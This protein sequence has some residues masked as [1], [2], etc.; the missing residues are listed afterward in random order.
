MPTKVNLYADGACS[1]NPG[2]GGWSFIL[3]CGT[4][5]SSSSGGEKET[6][7][8]R[9]ELLAVIRGLKALTKKCQV[10][11]ITD[12]QYVVKAFNEGWLKNWKS[13]GWRKADKSP[14][15]NQDLWIQLSVLADFHE[16]TWEWV[17]GHDV[18]EYNIRC[19][20]LAQSQAQSLK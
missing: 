11:I 15:A 10:T 9:M 5:E 14:V 16:C 17:K 18:N 6:T 7:N 8:N 19:D 13:K 4:H 2:P 12:S 3:T 1:G 20:K